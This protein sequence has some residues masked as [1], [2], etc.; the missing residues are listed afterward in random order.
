[1]LNRQKSIIKNPIN[2][3]INRYQSM[4]LVNWYRL[5]LA[6]RW[7]IDHYKIFLE[8]IDFH[9]LI[10]IDCQ[11]FSLIDKLAKICGKIVHGFYYSV[12][13]RFLWVHVTKCLFTGSRHTSLAHSYPCNV[14]CHCERAMN[15][16]CLLKLEN[17]FSQERKEEITAML[18]RWEMIE[19]NLVTYRR[20]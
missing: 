3:S 2:Q 15:V 9:R 16:H 1:M 20:I 19:D 13:L 17:N 11:G 5:I 18:L 7:S 6:N 8:I 14:W 10:F 4:E 12:W